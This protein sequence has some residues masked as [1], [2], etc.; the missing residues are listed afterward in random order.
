MLPSSPA[1]D[2]EMDTDNPDMGNCVDG[3]VELSMLDV[4]SVNML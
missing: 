3:D 2:G 1:D 4:Y